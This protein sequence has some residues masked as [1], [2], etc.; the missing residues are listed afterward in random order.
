MI[1]LV[2]KKFEHFHQH[3]Q[4]IVSLLN[5]CVVRIPE[6]RTPVVRTSAPSGD[7]YTIVGP[8]TVG[9]N[10]EVAVQ[11]AVKNRTRA[12]I[13]ISG[14]QAGTTDAQ[15]NETT[16]STSL[17]IMHKPTRIDKKELHNQ[18]GKPWCNTPPNTMNSIKGNKQ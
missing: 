6:T 18:S 9:D 1:L 15:T 4:V 12:T 5:L 7:L 8:A 3:I 2:V 14:L 17:A 16:E 13:R 11:E 10:E